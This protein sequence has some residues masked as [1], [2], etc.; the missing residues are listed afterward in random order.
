MSKPALSSHPDCT[1]LQSACVWKTYV[2][3][4]VISPVMAMA[5]IPDEKVNFPLHVVKPASWAKAWKPAL[6]SYLKTGCAKI[7]IAWHT[8]TELLCMA[9]Q[10][11]FFC[12]QVYYDY[13]LLWYLL[14]LHW[15][16]RGA[17]GLPFKNSEGRRNYVGPTQQQNSDYNEYLPPPPLV[18]HKRCVNSTG[19]LICQF[20][21]LCLPC[22]QATKNCKIEMILII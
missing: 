11:H 12:C 15:L 9:S 3:K 8:T 10:H 19:F 16:R 21:K 7:F 22:C 5:Y 6:P 2:R 14:P 13:Y 4:M 1:H 20:S 17:S 18:Y